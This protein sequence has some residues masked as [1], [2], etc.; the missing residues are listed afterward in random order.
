MGFSVSARRR[1]DDTK[2]QGATVHF[3]VVS[4][5]HSIFYGSL[6]VASC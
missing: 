2:K 4:K 3:A 1:Y 5:G 6:R